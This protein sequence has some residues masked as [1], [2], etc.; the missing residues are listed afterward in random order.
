MIP[1]K[2]LKIYIVSHI[3]RLI[4]HAMPKQTYIESIQ[5]WSKVIVLGVLLG[6]GLQIAHGAWEARPTTSPENTS[7]SGPLTT[8]NAFQQK[9]GSLGVKG[10]IVGGNG[11]IEIVSENNDYSLIDFKGNDAL[12]SDFESRIAS[13]EG[14]VSIF[15]DAGN[16]STNSKITLLS[17]RGQEPEWLAQFGKRTGDGFTYANINGSLGVR[18]DWYDNGGSN[19]GTNWAMVAYGRDSSNNFVASENARDRNGSINVNDVYLRSTEKWVSDTQNAV[20]V[21]QGDVEDI[22]SALSGLSIRSESVIIRESRPVGRDYK[23]GKESNT[24]GMMYAGCRD[25]WVVSG[26][27][28]RCTGD[29]KDMDIYRSGNGCKTDYNSSCTGSDPDLT[30]E[31]ICVQLSRP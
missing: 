5:Y 6:T 26:C 10:L 15:A 31:A 16:S 3:I 12:G 17:M 23:E 2:F 7:V 24:D 29:E 22:E 1:R 21:I 9:E 20:G 19:K 8:S 25:G 11:G 30:L 27:N 13:S 18:S 14:A 28:A 4:S